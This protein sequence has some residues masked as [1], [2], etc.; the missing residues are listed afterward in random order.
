MVGSFAF[1][2]LHKNNGP[3]EDSVRSVLGFSLL[4]PHVIVAGLDH[5]YGWTKA[6]P[7]WVH[8]IAFV[9][10]LLGYL[11]SAWAIFVNRFFSLV[12]RIQKDRGIKCATQGRIVIYAIQVIKPTHPVYGTS[13]F[14]G[15]GD[16]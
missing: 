2:L 15:Y 16:K 1:Y 13:L 4:Y 14:Q 8:T 11:L 5:Y 12:V 7:L 3:L 10:I 6:F 9:I